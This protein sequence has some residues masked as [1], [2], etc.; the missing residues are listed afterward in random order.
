MR[1]NALL[2]V[3]GVVPKCFQVATEEGQARSLLRCPARPSADGA[4][5]PLS[6]AAP[7]N[8]PC[9]RLWRRSDF[10]PH[11]LRSPVSHSKAVVQTLPQAIKNSR[12][13]WTAVFHW[14]RGQ[15]LNLRPPGYEPDELPSALP[16]DIQASRVGVLDYNSTRRDACQEVC[17]KNFLYFTGPAR[18]QPAV[19]TVQTYRCTAGSTRPCGP[20]VPRGCRAPQCAHAPIR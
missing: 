1:F 11:E 14:L 7:K 19:R 17:T 12:P 20:A 5:S 2:V 15:D 3:A 6:T 8:P 16:R 9:T 4:A 18:P 10:L 13:K